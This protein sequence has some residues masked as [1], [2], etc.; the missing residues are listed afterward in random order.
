MIAQYAAAKKIEKEQ[1][2][3]FNAKVSG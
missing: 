1:I 2:E 3:P